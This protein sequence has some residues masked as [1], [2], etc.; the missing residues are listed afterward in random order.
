MYDV[1]MANPGQ[2][3]RNRDEFFITCCPHDASQA[4]DGKF[5]KFGKVV[6]GFDAVH[7]IEAAKIENRPVVIADCGVLNSVPT[8]ELP[9]NS[10]N[11][12][13]SCA[14]E[15][16]MELSDTLIGSRSIQQV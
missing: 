3:N 10:L 7:A 1:S 5:V 8:E 2:C 6:S 13:E 12:T 11:T 15:V 4:L 9:V 14:Q 16:V